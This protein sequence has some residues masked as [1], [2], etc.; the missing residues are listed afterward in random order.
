M[1]QRM[2]AHVKDGLTVYPPSAGSNETSLILNRALSSLS[3]SDSVSAS[4]SITAGAVS[5]P[6]SSSPASLD[7]FN[8]AMDVPL[9]TSPTLR[10]SV[11]QRRPSVTPSIGASSTRSTGSASSA[12]RSNQANLGAKNYFPLVT[13]PNKRK[14]SLRDAADPLSGSSILAQPATE[15]ETLDLDG[16]A[17]ALPSTSPSSRKAPPHR[18]LGNSVFPTIAKSPSSSSSS[19]VFPLVKSRSL[20]SS[21]N[22]KTSAN[23][24]PF[25]DPPNPSPSGRRRSSIAPS[26]TSSTSEASSSRAGMP[27][28]SNPSASTRAPSL[29]SSR[30]SPS[31]YAPSIAPSSIEPGADG[32]TSIFAHP[33]GYKPTTLMGLLLPRPKPKQPKSTSKKFSS[34]FSS[35]GGGAGGPN[36]SA[37]TDGPTAPRHLI[38]GPERSESNRVLDAALTTSQTWANRRGRQMMMP[39]QSPAPAS[40][41]FSQMVG[42]AAGTGG[43]GGG[44]GGSAFVYR[45]GHQVRREQEEAR[46]KNGGVEADELAKRLESERQGREGDVFDSGGARARGGTVFPTVKRST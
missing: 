36:S 35:G 32:P 37:P 20:S 16:L 21:L 12:P 4:S 30:R 26:T 45:P 15:Q 1:Q 22:T 10:P 27:S 2:I 7:S 44:G 40:R 17:P 19:N 39:P 29:T 13:S 24:F 8:T 23:P 9:S 14:E 43:G 5:T 46:A 11:P 34:L 28:S 3:T 38:A 42:G 25:A 33:V 18:Q 31:G 41:P 6:P